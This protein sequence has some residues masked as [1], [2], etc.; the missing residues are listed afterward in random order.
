MFDR[1]VVNASP[2]IFLSRVGGIDWITRLSPQTIIVPRAVINEIGA[3]VDGPEIVGILTRNSRFEIVPDAPLTPIIAA[4]DLGTG[5]SQV[6]LQTEAR[7]GH[8]ALLDDLAARKCA[9]GLNIKIIGTLGIVVIARQKQ[10]IPA[11]RPVME[12][13]IAQG[14]FLSTHV[15][16]SALERLGE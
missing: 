4:W 9:T 14:M 1:L 11:A 3:G 7:P 5:E 10:W 13:L 16:M 8:I 2:L 12:S 15:M 6:L